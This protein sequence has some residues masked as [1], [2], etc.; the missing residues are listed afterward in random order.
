MWKHVRQ[1]FELGGATN[2]TWGIGY[3]NYPKWEPLI[4]ELWPAEADPKWVFFNAYGSPHRPN[5][6]DNVGAFYEGL[7]EDRW[8]PSS[9]KLWGIRE[10]SVK[11]LD[12]QPAYDYF[13][14]ARL[15]AEENAFPKLRA[16]VVFDSIGKEGL[17]EMRVGYDASGVPDPVKAALYERFAHTDMFGPVSPPD[18]R[19]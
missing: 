9:D 16:H 11:G 17:S 12:G 4:A 10:W 6:Q 15:A 13:T 14:S 18:P 8:F 3:M 1:V 5:Y 19:S 7:A 2:V